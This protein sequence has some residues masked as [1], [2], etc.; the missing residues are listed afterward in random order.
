MKSMKLFLAAAMPL[1]LAACGPM[2]LTVDVERRD[3]SR[4]GLDLGKKTFSVVYVDS[5]EKTDSVFSASMA[6]GFAQ[7]LEAEYFSGEQIIDIYRLDSI[8]GADYSSRDTLLN[9]LMDAGT[10]VVFLFEPPQFGIPAAGAPVKVKTGEKMSA[11]SSYVSEV[12]VPFSIKV[13]VYDSMNPADSV[14]S[15]MGRSTARPVAY[16]DGKESSQDLVSKAM[17]AIGEPAR[18]VGQKVGDTFASTWVNESF[19]VI[20]YEGNAWLEAAFAASDYRWKDA[21]DIWMGL[22][23]TGN[24]QKRSCAEYNIAFAC[25]MMGQY[26]LASE[27]LARSDKDYP[28]SVSRSLKK[29]I[30]ARL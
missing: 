23:D 5:G 25:Y 15:F 18:A 19:P 10:D 12:S 2:A 7:K 11:D 6:E 4:S 29:K 24:L 21:I 16:T 13:D 28:L 27:W 20:Y 30:D 14:F 22:L 1:A 3:I 9:I 26:D 8:P 17:S